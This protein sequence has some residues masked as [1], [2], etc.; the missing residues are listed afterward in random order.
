MVY[1][2]RKFLSK[3]PEEMTYTTI[4]DSCIAPKTLVIDSALI[5]CQSLN[6]LRQRSLDIKE[7]V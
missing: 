1:Y 6:R 2:F 4:D 5:K 3:P 7:K